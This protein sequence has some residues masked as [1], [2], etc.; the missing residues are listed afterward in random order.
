MI[1]HVDGSETHGSDRVE[2][3]VSLDGSSSV[4]AKFG[5]RVWFPDLPVSLSLS[6]SKLSRIN[7]WTSSSDCKTFEYQEA[8]FTVS[9]FF[10]SSS[11]STSFF[12]DV[13]SLVEVSKQ[14]VIYLIIA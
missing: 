7:G 1:V 3:L 2:V 6:D 14:T 13:T 5:V 9:T 8:R 11:N 12:A 4:V 10:R